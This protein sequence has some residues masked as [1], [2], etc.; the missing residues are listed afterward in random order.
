MAK[1]QKIYLASFYLLALLFSLLILELFLR[2]GFISPTFEHPFNLNFKVLLDREVL[3]K[4]KPHSSPEINNYGYRDREFTLEKSRK[5]RVLFLG[6]SF[7]MGLTTTPDKTLPKELERLLGQDYE[8]LNMG[9][10][11]YGPDQSLIQ[12]RDESLSFDPDMVI[13]SLF[14]SNDFDDIYK[15]RLFRLNENGFLS[16]TPYNAVT[17][18]IPALD[19]IYFLDYILYKYSV[20]AGYFKELF[21]ILHKDTFDFDLYRGEGSAIFKEKTALM[22]AIMEEFNK[23]LQSKNIPLVTIIMPY[24]PLFEKSIITEPISYRPFYYE[25]ITENILAEQ[26]LDSI[27]LYKTFSKYNFKQPLYAIDSG[28]EHLS[29]FGHKVAARVIYSY[30]KEHNLISYNE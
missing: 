4:V 29:A 24:G 10:Y 18:T 14:P 3:F 6:D 27:N 17:S 21:T 28:G 15:N 30:M 11:G 19:T 13:L 8:V 20:K 22:R 25:D 9:V 23:E 5:K 7:I 16:P 26:Q 12:L 2:I 1:K